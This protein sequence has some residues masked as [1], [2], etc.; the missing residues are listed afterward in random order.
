LAAALAVTAD[1]Q[2]AE[3][4]VQEACA[5]AAVRWRER[6]PD[7]PAAWLAGVARHK[8]LDS[9]R[10]E[11]LRPVKELAA[12]QG[13]VRDSPFRGEPAPLDAGEQLALLFLAGH[14]AF[15]TATRT[16]LML[17]TVCGLSTQ[18]IGEVLLQP[19]PTIAK[20]LVR[21]RRKIHESGMRFV[22]PD[23]AALAQR[24]DDVLAVLS[25]LYTA[26]QRTAAV[27]QP[28]PEL[29]RRAIAIARH[30]SELL[31]A[32][33][34]ALGLTAFLLFADARAAARFDTVGD[35]VLLVEQDRTRYDHA[36]VD[37]GEDLLER[38]LRLG[39]PGR[40]QLQAAIAACHVTAPT[41][42]ATDWREI[43]ALY[44]EL[45]RYDPSPVHEANR[46]IAVAEA[47]GPAA[48]LVILD[49]VLHHPRLQRWATMHIA[50]GTL[51]RR[52]G[53]LDDARAAFVTARGLNPASAERRFIDLQLGALPS[54]SP[55]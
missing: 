10:R 40:W 34:E 1:L 20:R 45:I 53:R 27:E 49:S 8:A 29:G 28:R 2:V 38:A 48:G 24:L 18:Q 39:R 16:T 23:P 50:R 35:P 33:P 25:L 13:R 42:S 9:V 31:P 26:G 14:P 36:Q 11:T 47:E 3:D 51:L 46:A 32:E 4:A 21:A 17:R 43:A 52:V 7:S 37:D 54:A 15:D 12:S 55:A 6:M 22:V 19:E 41:A 5:A 30:L 44:G